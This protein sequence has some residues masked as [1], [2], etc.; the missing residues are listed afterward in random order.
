MSYFR[1]IYNILGVFVGPTPA[2]GFH[3]Q[4]GNFSGANLIQQLERIQTANDSWSFA[5][6]DVNQFGQLGALDRIIVEPPTVSAEFTWRQSDFANERCLGFYT[7]GDATCVRDLL[8]KTQDEKNYFIAAAPEG[9]DLY[10]YSGQ[11]QV[12]QITNAALASY[13]AEGAIGQ[14]PTASISVEGLNWA[15]S[16]G[17]FN[18]VLKAVDRNAG[19]VLTGIF[20]TIPTGV[21]GI[22]T[23]PA[24]LRPGDTTVNIYN[25]A[26]GLSITDL[27]IQSYNISTDLNRENLVKMGLFYAFSKEIRWPV[28]VNLSITANIGDLNTGDLSM[29]YCND[30]KY[31][32]SVVMRD[33]SC[34]GGGNIAMIYDVKGAKING[35][36]QS[37]SIGANSA[38]TINYTAQLSGPSDTTQ[39]LF[40]SGRAW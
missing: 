37:K 33:P 30:Q 31:T 23:S 38:V 29:L 3:W 19:V 12:V 10:N 25:A 15:A 5:R 24:A 13:R 17:S 34:T 1:K 39:G 21:T 6:V 36:Q 40:M 27:K 11:S 35:E 20:F 22:P 32:V 9:I 18:Q 4:S 7:S 14:I 2:T 16:T 26:L 8:N 28:N